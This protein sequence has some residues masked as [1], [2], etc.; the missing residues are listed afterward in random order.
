MN[1]QETSTFKGTVSVTVIDSITGRTKQKFVVPNLVVTTGKNYIASRMVGDA[2]AVM[3]HMAVGSSAAAATLSDTD[4]GTELGRVALTSLTATGDTVT[5]TAT[6]P[7]GTGT[8]SIVEAG[9]FNDATDGSMLCRTVF[10]I[11]TKEA[12][13]IISI[14]WA[15]QAQ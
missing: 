3:S 15:I 14:S 9:I 11:V 1:I 12:I 2:S 10:P 6:F 4:V 8:G 7:A 13:D 5:A